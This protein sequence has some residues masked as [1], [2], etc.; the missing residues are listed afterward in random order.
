M[1]FTCSACFNKTFE[2]QF[3]F[4][5]V[6][7]DYIFMKSGRVSAQSVYNKH[8]P[9]NLYVSLVLPLN[10]PPGVLTDTGVIRVDAALYGRLNRMT[11]SVGRPLQ[12]LVNTRCSQDGTKD[13]IKNWYSLNLQLNFL[14]WKIYLFVH[15][16]KWPSSTLV[17]IVDALWNKIV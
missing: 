6:T 9:K 1:S 17:I 12:Q 7:G 16:Y 11:C 13:V 8:K 3:W 14:S 10:S 5:L 2:R 15:P 4:E